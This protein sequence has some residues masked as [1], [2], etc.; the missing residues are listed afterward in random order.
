MIHSVRDLI[1]HDTLRA[2]FNRA[3]DSLPEY[4]GFPDAGFVNDPLR[5]TD[6][7]GMY[8]YHF[9]VT[10]PGSRIVFD[11]RGFHRPPVVDG[12]QGKENE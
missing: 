3:K 4:R 10:R 1:A 7:N 6:K 12:E 9:S 5:S 2:Q 11:L 8:R